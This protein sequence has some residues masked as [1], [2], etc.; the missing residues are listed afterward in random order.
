MARPC[1]S[2]CLLSF[3]FYLSP[4][5]VPRSPSFLPRHPHHPDRMQDGLEKGQREDEKTQS[6]RYGSY[7]LPP[8]TTAHAQLNLQMLLFK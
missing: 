7:H 6:F 1:E 3:C 8:G 4:A 5:V 2:C